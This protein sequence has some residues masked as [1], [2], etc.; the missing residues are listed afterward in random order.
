MFYLFRRGVATKKYISVKHVASA[1]QTDKHSS[2]MSRMRA[3][4]GYVLIKGA[5][6]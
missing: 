1:T 3:F 2:S 6:S 4:F 5:S